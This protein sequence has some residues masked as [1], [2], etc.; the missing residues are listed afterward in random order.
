MQTTTGIVALLALLS[1]CCSL[2]L[3]AVTTSEA[4]AECRC[5][6]DQW[7]GVLEVVEREFEMRDGQMHETR[8]K[9]AVHYDFVNRRFATQDLQ[10]GRK[11]LADYRLVCLQYSVFSVHYMNLPHR[12]FLCIRRLGSLKPSSFLGAQGNIVRPTYNY[13]PIK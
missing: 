11:S 2:C 13:C 7:E 12:H 9:V 6:P 5:V 4:S 1:S 3:G 10:T 8:N